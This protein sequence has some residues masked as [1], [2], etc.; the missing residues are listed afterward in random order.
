MTRMIVICG[1]VLSLAA[2]G[3]SQA[4]RQNSSATGVDPAL[5]NSGDTADESL[6]AMVAAE[7]SA[8]SMEAS[9]AYDPAETGGPRQAQKPDGPIST[10]KF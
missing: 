7:N 5:L 9:N 2:C 8:A 1:F 4:P 3:E 10:G 6:N